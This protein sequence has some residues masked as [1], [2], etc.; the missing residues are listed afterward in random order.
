MR[1]AFWRSVL[2]LSRL[3]Y[4]ALSAVI[5]YKNYRARS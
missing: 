5:E 3:I 4:P 1:F 2:F